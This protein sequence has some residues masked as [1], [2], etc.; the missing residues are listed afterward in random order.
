MGEKLIRAQA[1]DGK[2]GEFRP[3]SFAVTAVDGVVGVGDQGSALVLRSGITIPVA[4]PYEVLEEKIYASDFREAVLDLRDVTGNAALS[5]VSP[6]LAEKIEVKPE[7][8]MIRAL[9]RKRYSTETSV[10]EF[11]ESDLALMTPEDTNRSRCGRSVT[12]TFNAASKI[13]P[14]EGVANLDMPYND[15]IYCL[16]N[17]REQGLET[18]DLFNIFAKNPGKYGPML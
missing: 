2:G 6:K 13:R 3:I 5:V 17:A 12:L 9:V 18:L 8:F 10:I 4:L 1:S 16:S 11:R 7:G 15:F 14:F